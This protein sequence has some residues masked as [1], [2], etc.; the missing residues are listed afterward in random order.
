MSSLKKLA[1]QTAIYGLSSIIGRFLNYLLVP[2]YTREFTQAEY[3]VVTELYAF[4]A[5]LI[6][7]ILYGMETAYF[8]FSKEEKEESVYSTAL[9]SVVFSSLAFVA[10]GLFF[11]ETFANFLHLGGHSEYI[12]WFV[13]VVALDAVTSIPFAKLRNDNKPLRFAA[14]KMFGIAINILV[15][16]Y[17]IWFCKNEYESNPNSNA[18]FFYNP[19]IGIGYIFI[20]NLVSS[21]FTFV[22]LAPQM[23]ALRS[24]FDAQLWKKMLKYA[25]PLLFLGVAGIINETLDRILLDYFLDL[26]P[27]ERKA[28]VGIYGACYKLAIVMTLAIQA[29]R[30]AAEPFFFSESKKENAAKTYAR[31]MWYFTAMMA[32]IYLVTILNMDLVKYFIGEAFHEGLYIVPV[33]LIANYF[34]GVYYNLSVWYKLTDKTKTGAYVSVFGALVTIVFNILL[35]PVLGYFGSAIATLICYFSMALVSFFLGQKHYPIPYQTTKIL[36]LLTTAV[37]FGYASNMLNTEGELV[38]LLLKN[39]LI[40]PFL[41]CFYLLNRGQKP[42]L[43]K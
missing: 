34:L 36:F 1:G 26:P 17:F 10:I 35:I 2:L 41:L 40:I 32:F 8:R 3:G 30:Y 12:T 37:F 23:L 11:S 18:L 6:V 28:Q 33:L 22:M 9:T 42:I 5:F 27:D 7:A 31:V 19:D 13:L 16:V 25:F 15:N 43:E 38:S 21:A 20:A 39:L 29:F 24:G 14:I 4:V